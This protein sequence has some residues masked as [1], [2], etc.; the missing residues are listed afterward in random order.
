M[1][2]MNRKVE[3][4]LMSLKHMSLK[5]TDELTS[6]K[7]VSDTLKTPFDATARV[8]QVM[9][10]RGLLRSEQGVNGGYS[11]T[12]D[13]KATSLLQLLEMIEGPTS[14]VKCFQKEA[15]CDIQNQCNIISPIQNLNQKYQDFFAQVTLNDLLGKSVGEL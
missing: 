2:K 14:L 11:I 12:G 8:M 1:N 7:E 5:P 15:Q 4:A 9:A 3:Y 6:A 10:Q 13:L